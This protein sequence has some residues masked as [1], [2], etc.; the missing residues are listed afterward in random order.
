VSGRPAVVVTIDGAAGSGK[1]T[2]GRRLAAVLG[3]PVVD[4]GLF[5]RGVMVAVVRR[6]LDIADA[7]SI[8]ALAA[9]IRIE[10]NIDPLADDKAWSLRV[11]GEDAGETARDP[12][13]APLLAD[14][15]ALAGV[16]AALLAPQRRLAAGGAVAV[17]RDCG[18]VVFPDA[19]L[20]LFLRAPPQVR[21]ERR[22]EELARRGAA[23]ETAA[24][25]AEVAGRDAKDSSR[26]ASP[27]RPAPDAHTI[28]TGVDGIESMVDRA[29]ELCRAAGLPLRGAR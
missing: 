7:A 23:V 6:G 21:A 2:L 12:R 1:T 29:L 3:L 26:A 15:S 5:Y 17:G 14:I 24:L 20:K 28:D 27:L 19:A 13:Y 8:A 10:V 18:T 11:D 16:R 9:G 25:Q 4:T 22:A